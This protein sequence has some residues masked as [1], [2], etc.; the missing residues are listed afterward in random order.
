M[1]A[2]DSR[3]VRT[4]ICDICG[5]DVRTRAALARSPGPSP[6][7]SQ[8]EGGGEGTIR[9]DGYPPLRVGRVSIPGPQPTHLAGPSPS[10]P[11]LPRLPFRGILPPHPAEEEH[12]VKDFFISYN[13]ADRT[14][15]A[16]IAHWLTEAGSSVVYQAGDFG[17]GSNFILEMD[18]AAR[19]AH[20]TIAVLSPDYLSALY[21]HPEWAAALARDPTGKQRL[22]IPVRVREC[23]LE[24]LLAQVVYID[25]VGLDD[26]AARTRFLAGVAGEPD[27]TPLRPP[28]PDPATLPD[29]G[30]LPPGSR[31]PFLRNPDFTGRR[32]PLLALAGA[33]L[34]APSGPALITQ[35]LTGMGGTGKTQLAV[36]FSYRFGRYFHGVHWLDARDPAALESEV[37]ACG[38]AMA[39]PNWP[40]RQPEQVARTL[41]AWRE[42]GP[43]LVV[44]DNL[45]EVA[46]AREWLPR[47]GGPTLRLLLTARRAGWPRFLGL[48]ALPLDPFTPEESHDFLRCS[49]P[50]GRA[51]DIEIDVLARHLGRLPLALQ[52]AARYLAAR[53]RLTVHDY[54]D[55]LETVLDHPSMQA[56]RPDLGDATAHDLSLAATFFRSWQE[57][58]DDSARRLFL[59][60]GHCAPNRPIPCALLEE[61]AGLDEPAC[62]E[63]LSLLAGLGL[64][65]L[66]DP[67]AG[68][69]VHPLLAE[70]AR[71]LSPLPP[72]PA[73]G[74]AKGQG[75]GV[76]EAF[77][78]L[79]S[80]A[81]ALARLSYA[82][83][84]TGLP[85]SFYPLRPHLEAALPAV[86]A[87][88]L[89]QAGALWNNLGYHLRMVADFSRARAAY[90]RA[91]AIF[92]K[93]LGPDHPNFATLVNNLG[94]VLQDLGDLPAARAAF[95]R[96][97]AIDERAY[98]PDHPTV[99]RDVNNLGGVLY[100]LADLPAARAAY[101]RALA[102]DERAYG[103]DHPDVAI[104]VNNLG[105]VLQSLGDLPAARAACERALA[106]DERAYGPDHPTVAIRVNN[107]GSVLQD[108]GDLPAARAAHERALS[109]DERAYGPDHPTV[110]IRVNNLGLVLQALGDLAAAR[111]A[112]ERAL[113]I[114]ERAYGPD[115]PKVA[116]DVNNLG[117]VLYA[118]GDLPAA[119]AAYER[120]LRIREATLPPGHPAIQR[121]RANLASLP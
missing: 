43:R 101:E 29:P 99:A 6:S 102:I 89:E 1:T 106:I 72:E 61:A 28:L 63:A 95:E 59:V 26:A 19:E 5:R 21:T 73:L 22:L 77:S 68:P 57:V 90:E 39:L 93:V 67:T 82:A 79:P 120:A 114:D 78:P 32:E 4:M 96:A 75:Q 112:C 24:G 87:A 54:L 76:R 31:L 91:L 104:D 92:E 88:G 12:P 81:S 36:E 98:G 25:L 38:L 62:D 107:L 51:S 27:L 48:G 121:V 47:L 30:P 50:E 113:A 45:E 69:A 94:G 60:C 34:H 35:A 23:H 83:T 86:D 110:A 108:L 66:D 74:E 109:I 58:A 117:G 10:F 71:S 53:P 3:Y 2:A 97:L 40:D 115:H 100:A 84:Q 80:L 7:P 46:A 11:H 56:W 20:R 49:L 55:Q 65:T 42:S 18:T 41:A 44:L 33:L 37:A 52:L 103:P 64:L 85:A 116:T 119:R 118:L 16:Q 8:G 9:T 111:A 13:K 15:A 17:P 70:Y 14:W 105:S